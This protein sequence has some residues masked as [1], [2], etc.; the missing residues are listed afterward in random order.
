MTGGIG[1]GKSTVARFLAECGAEVVVGDELGK[2]AID[3]QPDVQDAIRAR[4]GDAVFESK[5]VLNRKKLGDLVFSESL[6]VRWLTELT[7]PYIY[8]EWNTAVSE[9]RREMI[10]FDAA[11]IF[12]WGI[13]SEF[14]KIVVVTANNDL[15][16]M[17]SMSGRFS[18]ETLAQRLRFQ[19]P[20]E[21]KVLQANVII[22]NSGTIETLRSKVKAFYKIWLDQRNGNES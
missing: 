11:L 2:R 3:L 22:E 12:E 21:Q 18:P 10:V 1:T 6:N 17:R 16:T 5:G 9:C 4:F 14:D 8:R 7:F 13:Q 20:T 19:L 15:V